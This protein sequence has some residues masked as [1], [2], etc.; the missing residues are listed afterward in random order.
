M[1]ATADRS[2]Q[3]FNMSMGMVN[4]TQI[5]NLNTT[6]YTPVQR[7]DGVWVRCIRLSDYTVTC[8][9]Y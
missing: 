8:K 1:Q 4:Q 7:S 5:G 9:A 3:T 6:S 2:T